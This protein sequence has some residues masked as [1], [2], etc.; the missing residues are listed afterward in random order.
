MS[1]AN[2]GRKWVLRGW[3]A[4]L[5]L[6]FVGATIRGGS[7]F[8]VGVLLAVSVVAYLGRQAVL[9]YNQ[10]TTRAEP[11][12]AGPPDIWRDRPPAVVVCP[13]CDSGVYQHRPDNPIDCPSCDYRSDVD[14]I[15]AYDIIRFDCPDCG[16]DIEEGWTTRDLVGDGPPDTIVWVG[17][18]ECDMRWEL[19]HD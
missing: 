2:S 13:E 1:T 4:F 14:Y 16:A 8:V 11:G 10:P 6:G 12:A 18:G 9:G 7:T 19:P 3:F 15:T 5:V 17:C